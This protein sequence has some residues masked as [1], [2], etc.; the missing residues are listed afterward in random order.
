VLE[1]LRERQVRVDKSCVS[2]AGRQCQCHLKKED[3]NS[4][5]NLTAAGVR[6]RASWMRDAQHPPVPG[7][8][9]HPNPKRVMQDTNDAPPVPLTVQLL[10]VLSCA[11]LCCA[12]SRS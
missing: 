11:V 12:L 6:G 8:A 10:L 5:V 2:P 3:C 1:E 9:Q 7:G 4:W